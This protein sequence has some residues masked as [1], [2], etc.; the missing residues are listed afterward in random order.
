MAVAQ[1]R[2][3]TVF[4]VPTGWAV[5]AALGAG[6]LI[7]VL[8]GVLFS[9]DAQGLQVG[10]TYGA[11]LGLPAAVAVVFSRRSMQQGTHLWMLALV[12]VASVAIM[13]ALLFALSQLSLAMAPAGL[14]LGAATAIVALLVG[15]WTAHRS[16]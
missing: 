13:A 10:V 1:H 12:A 5:A 6:V 11:I 8:L 3:P 4:A 7:G 9:P 15:L 2:A 16:A 14:V